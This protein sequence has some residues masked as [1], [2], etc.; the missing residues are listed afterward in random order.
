MDERR[1][2]RFQTRE[3]V[4]IYRIYFLVSGKCYIGQTCDLKR[5]LETHLTADSLVGLALR[6]HDDWVPSV[7]HTC[8]SRDEANRVEIEEIRNFN[9]VSPGGYNLTHGGESSGTGGTFSGRHHTD[10]SLAKMSKSHIGVKAP[11]VSDALKGGKQSQEHIEKRRQ[12]QIGSKHT[13]ETKK[14]MSES[15]FERTR[16]PFSDEAKKNMGKHCKGDKNPM[17]RPEVIAKSQ[18]TCKKTKLKKLQAQMNELKSGLSQE[19]LNELDG[20]EGL[21]GL[22]YRHK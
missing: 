21:D 13:D 8:Y 4:Y 5:R 11:W 10:E 2:Q 15:A 3:V 14:K 18:L 22:L 1:E 9:S 17:C 7:L 20:F 12:K 16:R 19:V 6:K